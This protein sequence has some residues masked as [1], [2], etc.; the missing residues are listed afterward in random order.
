LLAVVPQPI[1]LK[2]P[3]DNAS[4]AFY[5]A[6]G[7]DCFDTEDGRKRRLNVWQLQTVQSEAAR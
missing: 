3:V 4:N 5:E 1:R 6:R 2:C 7:F